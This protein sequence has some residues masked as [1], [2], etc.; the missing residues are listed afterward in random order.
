MKFKTKVIIA[1]I[2]AAIIIIVLAFN[3]FLK[4][5]NGYTFYTVER[6]D[7]YKEITETGTIKKGDKIL[8]SF[9][10]TGQLKEIYVEIGDEV[11]EGGLL[12][13]IDNVQLYIQLEQARAE[14][15]LNQAELDKL[16]AGSTEEEIQIAQTSI[17]NAKTTLENKEK[18]L[19][20]TRVTANQSIEDSYE[21]AFNVLNNAHLDLYNAFA[22]VKSIQTSYF[23]GNDQSSLN[24]KENRNKIDDS[25]EE[26]EFYLDK[27]ETNFTEQNINFALVNF[28]KNLADAR[29][30]LSEIRAIIEGPS[31]RNVVSSSDKTSL[32]GHRTYINTAYGNIIG[33]QQD[34]AST[35]ISNK[36]NID[37]AESTVATAQD[38]LRVAEDNLA[39]VTATPRE[40]DINSYQAKVKSAQARVDILESQIR[41]TILRSPVDG[42]IIAVENSV[43]ETVQ[44]ASPVISILPAEPF[45]IE[46]NVYEEDIVNV[47]KGNLAKIALVAFPEEVF[48]GRVVFINPAEKL[49]DGIVYYEVIINFEAAPEGVKPG[50][51]ADVAII[52]LSKDNVLM[53]PEDAISEEEGDYVNIYENNKPKLQKVELGIEGSN[54]MIEIIS[55]LKEGQEIIVD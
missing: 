7:V 45:K 36:T 2:I 4:K 20:N 22:T 46:L 38:A 44:A 17:D 27:A 6:G 26:M 31:Y 23:T 41:D 33:E 39:L 29:D 30:S 11:K 35:K 21:D 10:N 42:T 14:L 43:K 19:E 37:T 1:L 55:G 9:K 40:E 12:A 50:M 53:I 32:D 34:I 15:E 3:F 18:D 24:I 49:I 5:N 48:E 25:L 54:N 52:F 8:L 51:T 47:R 16:M 28:D 13:K